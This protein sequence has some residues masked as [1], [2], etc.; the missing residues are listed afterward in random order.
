MLEQA[1]K[2]GQLTLTLC[3]RKGLPL[4]PQQAAESVTQTTQQVFSQ[5][6]V[7][8]SFWA[9]PRAGRGVLLLQLFPFQGQP[10]DEMR[11]KG[12]RRELI[13]ASG[14]VGNFDCQGQH[15]PM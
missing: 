3:P 12:L 6:L 7:E 1:Y 15:L 4:P 13:G 5:A 8:R 9:R 2:G 14:D 10:A 11:Q